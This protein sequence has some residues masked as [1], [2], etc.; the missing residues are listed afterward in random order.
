[1]TTFRL[2]KKETERE[3][4][5]R[6]AHERAED[7]MKLLRDER[8]DPTKAVHGA[9]KDVKKLRATLRL[10]RPALGD[11][12]YRRENDRYRHAGR[13]LSD[14]RDAQVRADTIDALAERFSADPPPGGWWSLRALLVGEDEPAEGDLE[15]LRERVATE[16][17]A[18]EQAIG[19]WPLDAV[20]F[21]LLGPGLRRAYSRACKSFRKARA[22][23]GDERLHEW[24]KRS[25]DL[26]YQLRLLRRAWPAVIS[27]MADEAHR[28]SDL[29]GD[30]H[31]LVILRDY[32]NQADTTLTAEQRSHLTRQIGARREELQA[33][34]FAYGERLLAEKPKR[35]VARLERYW[36]AGKL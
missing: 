23:P 17:A 24:R 11:A 15:S 27:A 18:G 25:K 10:V 33:E 6:V 32:V 28:L 35:F 2:R 29:L 1:V 21:E 7:A 8:A 19:S 3:G 20:G 13:A 30:D 9:R 26:W 22:K 34:A 4:I 14:A 12:A 16:I 31:D 36:G 5:R